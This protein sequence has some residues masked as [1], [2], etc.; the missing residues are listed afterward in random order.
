M[1]TATLVK[2]QPSGLLYTRNNVDEG[3]KQ[4]SI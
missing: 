2:T 4:K 3:H 1:S